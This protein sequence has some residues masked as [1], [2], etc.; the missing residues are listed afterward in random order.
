MRLRPTLYGTL[1]GLAIALAAFLSAGE[2]LAE[3]LHLECR[4]RETRADGARR[5]ML[6]RLDIDLDRKQVRFYDN[7]GHGWVFRN[8]YGFVAASRERITLEANPEKD[9]YIDRATGEYFLHN[10][11][12]GLMVRGPCVKTRAERPRF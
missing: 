2:T 11:K 3:T 12:E 1:A 8:E 7:A 9:S 4:V 6:R 5:E 10:K